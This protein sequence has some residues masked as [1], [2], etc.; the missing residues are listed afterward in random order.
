VQNNDLYKTKITYSCYSQS[1]GTAA[2]I[3]TST[4]DGGQWSS[5]STGRFTL[6]ETA[7]QT[8][9]E[10]GPFYPRRNNRADT[11]RTGAA[12]PSEKQPRRHPSNGGRFTLRER[13]TPTPTK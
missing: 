1:E 2:L 3:L 6:V 11:H 13:V 12:L 9:I 7:A 4:L 5:S 10:R 8:P